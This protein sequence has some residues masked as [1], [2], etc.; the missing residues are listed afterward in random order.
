VS[1]WLLRHAAGAAHAAIPAACAR[2]IAEVDF[3]F[4]NQPPIACDYF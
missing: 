3:L 4:K 1:H 2:K